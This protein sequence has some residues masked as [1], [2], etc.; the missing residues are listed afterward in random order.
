MIFPDDFAGWNFTQE[1]KKFKRLK[2][3]GKSP[4][5]VEQPG[6]SDDEGNLLL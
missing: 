5:V 3:A 6:V 2:K 1:S 4:K